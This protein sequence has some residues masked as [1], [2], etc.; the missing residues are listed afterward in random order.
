[1]TTSVELVV[2]ERLGV[3][4][5]LPAG[6]IA[7]VDDLPPGACSAAL[8]QRLGQPPPQDDERCFGLRVDA[9]SGQ[10]VVE[11]AGRV[12]IAT[13]PAEDIAPLPALLSGIAPI[14]AVVFADD[15]ASVLVLD[16]DAAVAH[17]RAAR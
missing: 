17:A 3:R 13:V 7:A 11:V 9:T 15:E 10:T 8:Q 1:M 16:V 5:G 4:I 12:S 6:R 2:V 14:T